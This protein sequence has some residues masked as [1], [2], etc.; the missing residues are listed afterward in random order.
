[1]HPVVSEPSAVNKVEEFDLVDTG[2]FEMEKSPVKKIKVKLRKAPAPREKAPPKPN[3]PNSITLSQQRSPRDIIMQR[4][5]LQ[6]SV[7]P[8]KKPVS[9]PKLNLNGMKQENTI[10]KISVIK[11]VAKQIKEK[12]IRSKKK[13]IND[14]L[15]NSPV[16]MKFKHPSSSPKIIKISDGLDK[17]KKEEAPE[18]FVISDEDGGSEMDEPET[19]AQ[20]VSTIYT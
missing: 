12:K 2:P 20:R 18:N 15:S 17:K 19:N 14:M 6:P 1:M 3:K 7:K 11:G 4:S 13:N 8:Q 10:K 16:K 5:K 9:V